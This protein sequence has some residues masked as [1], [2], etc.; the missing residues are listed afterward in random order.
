M[1]G[2]SNNGSSNG[3]SQPKVRAQKDATQFVDEVFRRISLG[4]SLRAVCADLKD[5]GCP[6]SSAFV[7]R[8]MDDNPPGIATRY[9]RA[10]ELQCEAWADEI[11]E[12]S[13]TAKIGE[14]TERD[15]NGSVVKVTTGDTVERSR[16]SVDAKKWLLAKL[17]PK[18][19]G[20]KVQVDSS[21]TGQ[22]TI[23]IEVVHVK[24]EQ[25]T[26]RFTFGAEQSPAVSSNGETLQN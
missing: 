9:A 26:P 7:Q 4:E 6:T 16:L 10:R 12:E 3:A 23:R 13:R 20:E 14:K 15:A 1:A 8:V 22:Q 5:F 2:G 18:K 17:H 11:Y 21:Q 19:Y 24:P 25:V